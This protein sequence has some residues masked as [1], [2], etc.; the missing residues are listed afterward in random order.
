[1]GGLFYLILGLKELVFINRRSVSTLMIFSIILIAGFLLYGSLDTW[2]S[3]MPV[4]TLIFAWLFW[5]L[6]RGF[7][8]QIEEPHDKYPLALA[9]MAFLLWEIGTA[10]AF[11]P[12][13]FVYQTTIVVFAAFIF[14]EW[15]TAYAESRLSRNKILLYLSFFFILITLIFSFAKWGM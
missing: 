10:A 7:M 6:T 1:M 4:K 12:L 15:L 13:D 14:F 5:A 3:W 2:S 9:V 11:L 8:L